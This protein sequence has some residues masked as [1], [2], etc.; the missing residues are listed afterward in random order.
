MSPYMEAVESLLQVYLPKYNLSLPAFVYTP[1][2]GVG[3][4]Y[5]NA[6]LSKCFGTS[7]GQI[8]Q[9]PEQADMDP[10]FPT[11]QFPNPEEAG[12]LDLAFKE[13]DKH[14]I[15]LVIAN[16]PDADRFSAAEKDVRSGQWAMFTGNEV[17]ILLAQFL[18][19]SPK[20][21]DAKEKKEIALM[22]T[23][24]STKMLEAMAVKDGFKYHQ[25]LTGFKWMGNEA[26][27]LEQEGF[28]VPFAFEEALGY[29]FPNVVYDKDG[30]AAATMFLA[31]YAKWQE[32]EPDVSLRARYKRISDGY[33]Y[34]ADANSYLKRQ[35]PEVTNRIFQDIRGL[36]G[37]SRPCKLISRNIL[38]WI[39]LTEG[40]DSKQAD[41]KPIL[42][43]DKSSQ[44]I[45]FV[46][47]A[48]REDAG[49]VHV[50]IRGSGT[51]PKIKIYVEASSLIGFD[52]ALQDA[53]AVR[54][55]IIS[56]WMDPHKYGLK[57]PGES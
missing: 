54:E 39:D 38:R 8:L 20:L 41:H 23:V 55:D 19:E 32:E 27:R 30:V 47:E 25:T 56:S 9:V 46:L 35:S 26:Q 18:K 16:D 12:A 5:I 34:Y 17:G 57:R 3:S 10:E 28:T 14:G 22:N 45:M 33:G 15:T 49:E 1:L 51:E 4:K 50:T 11:V 31:A 7:D 53:T 40:F 42:P 36:D 29:M 2:H 21:R 44:M 52:Q 6:A 48:P 37:G 43:I 24:V 13:A